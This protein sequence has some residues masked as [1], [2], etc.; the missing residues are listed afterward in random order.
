MKN[1]LV[2]VLLL[3]CVGAWAQ[4]A[5]GPYFGGGGTNGS[6]NPT[7][8]AGGLTNLPFANTATAYVDILGSDTAGRVSAGIY[9][10]NAYPFAT[11][12]AAVAALNLYAVNYTNL[13]VQIGPGNFLE[14]TNTVNP[15]NGVSIKGSGMFSTVV[16]SEAI[17]TTHGPCIGLMTN[18]T[19]EDLTV[20][21]DLV[22][23]SSQC[24]IGSVANYSTNFAGVAHINN[25]Q[26][27][28]DA[29]GFL[30]SGNTNVGV[31]Y[32]R[33][34]LGNAKWDT[35]ANTGCPRMGFDV[36]VATII[37]LGPSAT[38]SGITRGIAL[39]SGTNIFRNV[40]VTALGGIG[41]DLGL[42]V[43]GGTNYFFNMTYNTGTSSAT[44]TKADIR[45]DTSGTAA[46]FGGSMARYDTNAMQISRG[47]GIVFGYIDN[48]DPGELHE[49]P[50]GTNVQFPTRLFSFGGATITVTN[51]LSAGTVQAQTLTSS[52]TASVKNTMLVG[53]P[54]APGNVMLT[55]SG[56]GAGNN[57][58]LIQVI[59]NG[60]AAGGM[61][62]NTFWY[63]QTA[64]SNMNTMGISWTNITKT[65]NYSAT[66]NDGTIMMNGSSLTNVLPDAT[67]LPSQVFTIKNIN[68]AIT[69]IIPTNSQTIDG[70]SGA[71]QMLQNESVQFQ[72]DG[73]NWRIIGGN[74]GGLLQTNWV[75]G[76]LYTNTY[77]QPIE[78]SGNATLTVAAVAGNATMALRITG[79]QTNF[80]SMSTLVTSIAMSYTNYLAIKVP[81]GGVFTWTNL[82]AGAGNSASVNGG[83]LLTQ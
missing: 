42:D 28:G 62:S 52:N 46:F 64:F 47:A 65:A 82:S 44:S 30:L 48:I 76:Q 43:T 12:H 37:D 74:D 61:N 73:S 66:T 33:N 80:S 8:N 11:V 20:N 5:Q 9:V 83:Q 54:S 24:P 77:G 16:Q 38:G 35:F 27:I 1:I 17:T 58:D 57:A 63:G 39:A 50:G 49:L 36:D 4:P 56:W 75:S 70:A 41:T 72:S 69:T 29:D 55:I 81:A 21:A 78:V 40:S 71:I 7:G 10:T 51:T 13:L 32:V 59:E 18:V 19:I 3:V 23:G 68:S 45:V 60:V 79:T 67:L 53:Q 22:N 2:V 26:T 25:V 34:Y 6:S 31:V 14:G 15:T